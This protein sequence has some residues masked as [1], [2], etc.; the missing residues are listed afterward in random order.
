MSTTNKLFI[1]F[2]FCFALA[3]VSGCGSSDTLSGEWRV[4]EIYGYEFSGK[5]F[6]HTTWSPFGTQTRNGTYSFS[7]DG[8]K[9]EF[10]FSDGE[11]VVKDFERTENTITIGG[12][13]YPRK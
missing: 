9:I 3:L 10:K 5:S 8:K 2:L 6:T 12:A 4:N 1:S 7:K 13:T 11:V